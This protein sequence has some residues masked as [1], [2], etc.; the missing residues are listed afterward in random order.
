[1]HLILKK[2]KNVVLKFANFFESFFFHSTCNVTTN[3][4][5]IS[6]IPIRMCTYKAGFDDSSNKG[7]VRMFICTIWKGPI[8]LKS[9]EEET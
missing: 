8:T 6:E 3:E 5:Q 4:S 7:R 9:P 2:K 1:M